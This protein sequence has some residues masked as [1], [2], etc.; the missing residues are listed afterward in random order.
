MARLS[1]VYCDR[2]PRFGTAADE[3]HLVGDDNVCPDCLD[4]YHDSIRD[5]T[6]ADELWK[7]R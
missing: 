5:W 6:L 7:E 4:E 3:W 2:C 1:Y